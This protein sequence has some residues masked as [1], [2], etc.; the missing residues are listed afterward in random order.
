MYGGNSRTNASLSVN[1]NLTLTAG[2]SYYLDVSSDAMILV[3]PINGQS[4]PTFTL[5]FRVR[6]VQ[7]T[8]LEK[9]F[10]GPNGKSELIVMIVTVIIVGLLVG[11]FFTIVIIK[12]WRI[13]RFQEEFIKTKVDPNVSVDSQRQ[14]LKDFSKLDQK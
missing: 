4:N 12:C 11:A 2:Q 10:I 8:S 3:L 5:S 14:A 6:G 13:M 7:Y 1:G 9:W